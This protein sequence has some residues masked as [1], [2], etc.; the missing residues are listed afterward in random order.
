V[1][2][3]RCGKKRMVLSAGYIAALALTAASADCATSLS[4]HGAPSSESS[5]SAPGRDSQRGQFA[6]MD[7][8]LAQF[9][10]ENPP[11]LKI[12]AVVREDFDRLS[13]RS[14]ILYFGHRFDYEHGVPFRWADA[15]AAG[16]HEGLER[17]LAALL[18]SK[19]REVDVGVLVDIAA[20]LAIT[21]GLSRD[22]E[23]IE[24]LEHVPDDM[25]SDQIYLMRARVEEVIADMK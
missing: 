23:L 25:A 3:T 10:A 15:I 13:L 12:P 4:M 22:K 2:L 5:R 17:L 8:Q 7:E 21:P 11:T 6:A 9:A 16:P 24:V 19:N 20:S 18:R 1:Q 14:K